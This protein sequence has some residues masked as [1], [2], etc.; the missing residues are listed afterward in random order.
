MKARIYPALG[1]MFLTLALAAG[2]AANLVCPEAQDGV[3]FHGTLQGAETDVVTFPTLSVDGSGTG[4]ATHLGKFQASWL[5]TVNISIDPSPSTGSLEFIAADG[6]RLFTDVVGEG[7]GAPL[8]HITECNTITGG[9]GRFAGAS[10]AFAIHRVVDLATGDTSGSFGGTL[11]I[12][13][14]K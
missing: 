2:A 6:S 14:P 9:T 11:V 8:A 1:A 10:G 4:N 12:H 5:I 7:S 13:P 3:P